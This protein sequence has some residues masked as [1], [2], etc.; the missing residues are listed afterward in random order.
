MASLTDTR[1]RWAGDSL[2]QAPDTHITEAYFK[3][4]GRS[5]KQLLKAIDKSISEARNVGMDGHSEIRCLPI[6]KELS[7]QRFA[8]AAMLLQQL[9]HGIRKSCFTDGDLDQRAGGDLDRCAAH[10]AAQSDIGRKD[11]TEAKGAEVEMCNALV[12]EV[13]HAQLMVP[14]DDRIDS[15]PSYDLIR[16]KSWGNDRKPA[17]GSRAN[18]SRANVVCTPKDGSNAK[19]GVGGKDGVGNTRREVPGRRTAKRVVQGRQGQNQDELQDEQELQFI[20]RLQHEAGGTGAAIRDC[21][22]SSLLRRMYALQVMEHTSLQPTTTELF[23]ALTSVLQLQ[24]TGLVVHELQMMRQTIRA[25]AT[26]EQGE[27]S[28]F[29]V[30]NLRRHI[31]HLEHIGHGRPRLAGGGGVGTDGSVFLPEEDDGLL[32]PQLYASELGL[33]G[34]AS[35][36]SASMG[37]GSASS[38]STALDPSR[39]EAM[40]TISALSSIEIKGGKVSGKDTR[41]GIERSALS[42]LDLDGATESAWSSA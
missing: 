4:F 24:R 39:L 20:Q 34:S 38:I 1:S 17:N 16:P 23:H 9:D 27:Q 29:S 6:A 36:G 19:G 7:A 3:R 13:K 33:M 28:S 37:S 15:F 32:T 10:S 14:A 18:G 8:Q 35:M 12:L 5:R 42:L 22:S 25:E 11:A 2:R 31:L 21:D 26:T 41:S 40:S 30:D